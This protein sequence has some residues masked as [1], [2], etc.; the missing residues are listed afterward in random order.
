M[1]VKTTF[2][3][4][5]L[6]EDVYMEQSNGFQVNGK[7]HRVCRLKRSIYGLKQASRQ[8]YLK[9]DEIVTSYDFKENIVDQCI[10]L[11][12]SGSTYIF[13]LLY[14]DDILLATND[15]ELLLKTKRMLSSHFDI[16]DLG[17]AFYVLS[18]QILHDRTK[19]ALG[20]SQKTCIDP[21]LN[22]FHMQYCSPEK[23][24][25][26]K[27]DIYPKC[28]CPQNDSERTQMQSI[29]Y[30]SVVGSLMYAQVC[31]RLDI[32]YAVSVLGR[33]LND[34]GLNH[35]TIAKKVLRYL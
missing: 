14:M 23:T 20:L 24:P 1:D 7:E 21:V 34:P 28:Q 17:E 18:I 33:Y 26:V 32:A 2:L 6:S 4:D 8:W 15:N 9:F 3:D 22:R 29:P 25:I 27:G 13:L 5:H 16:K 12:I 30:A 35:W 10:Y 31:T 19:G 11:R